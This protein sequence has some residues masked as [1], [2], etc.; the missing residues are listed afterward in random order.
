MKKILLL[1][2]FVFVFP[3]FCFADFKKNGD[4]TITDNDT[5]LIWLLETA[6]IDTDGDVDVDDLVNWENALIYCENLTFAGESDWRLPTINELQSIVDYTRPKDPYI[7]PNF[8]TTESHFYWTSTTIADATDH[9][10]VVYF[11][12]GVVM[13][14]PKDNTV[15]NINN[16]FYVRAVRGG[17]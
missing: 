1:S 8:K 15:N 4:G 9:V 11:R 10:W 16:T 7:Y 6:D 14:K 5:S 13:G 12:D 2:L 3:L 17:Q